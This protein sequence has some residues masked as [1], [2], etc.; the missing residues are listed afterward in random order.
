[1]AYYVDPDAET[2]VALHAD[3]AQ[4]DARV[5]QVR[6][7]LE[8]DD[9]R[10]CRELVEEA[11]AR[12]VTWFRLADADVP[13]NIMPKKS[14]GARPAQQPEGGGPD[15][16]GAA[17][18]GNDGN[19]GG[20]QRRPAKSRRKMPDVRPEHQ[21]AYWA[22]LEAQADA[23]EA[24]GEPR[25]I[26][27]ADPGDPEPDGQAVY[28]DV[29]EEEGHRSLGHKQA[30]AL[31]DERGRDHSLQKLEARWAA[32]ALITKTRV[33]LSR[34][35]EPEARDSLAPAPKDAA[36]TTRKRGRPPKASTFWVP[37]EPGEPIVT[38]RQ[39]RALHAMPAAH[40]RAL[41]DTRAT[42]AAISDKVEREL[43]PLRQQE[44]A[45]KDA[46][47]SKWDA[48]LRRCGQIDN[49]AEGPNFIIWPHVDGPR[50]DEGYRLTYLHRHSGAGRTTVP[51]DEL[52]R[53]CAEARA[54]PRLTSPL[55][56]FNSV[57]A[58]FRAF[59]RPQV[60]TTAARKLCCVLVQGRGKALHHNDPS[61][62]AKPPNDN[63]H[64]TN[65]HQDHDD[66]QDSD[67]DQGS[68]DHY[69]SEDYYASDTQ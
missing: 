12:G 35:R 40:E 27:A 8:T 58:A 14:R 22:H 21:E 46:L 18:P 63:S 43:K 68:Q 29:F 28:A 6:G 19:H 10:V 48:N 47:A 53:W 64:P 55:L 52:R 42:L 50:K 16:D 3:I 1:M 38:P 31:L 59:T 26:T 61:H 49:P 51:F 62:P 11:K 67:E 25:E 56:Q 44:A 5:R 7:P 60:I 39:R 37:P 54:D 41:I 66:D 17:D 65:D 36:T 30:L 34:G 57:R 23:R 13:D 4:K 9:R 15:T 45:L 69:A 2:M 24:A 33:E 20:G 32:D